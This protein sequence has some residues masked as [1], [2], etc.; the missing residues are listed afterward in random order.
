MW[1]GQRKAM[2]SH[3]WGFW[4][5]NDEMSESRI[6]THFEFKSS[7]P[8]RFKLLRTSHCGTTGSVASRVVPGCRFDP[9]QR[10]KRFGIAKAAA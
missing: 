5:E 6:I 7:N 2:S 9:Q 3:L 8:Y 10:V 4:G 1:G